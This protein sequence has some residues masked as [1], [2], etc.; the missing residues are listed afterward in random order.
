MP[1]TNDAA[2]KNPLVLAFV[3]DAY[4]T[5]Y[6]R[7]FLI[8]RSN[9]KA[10]KL[11]L[12]ANKYVCATAQAAFYE[13]IAPFLNETEIAIAGRARNAYNHTT[14]KNCTLAEYKLSTAFE[15]VV[16][17]NYLIGKFKH[18]DNLFDLILKEKL[19]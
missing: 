6:V 4:W 10:G 12:S 8:E 15:A 3:G 7:N 1:N 14:P 17:Y 19:C 11:H 13:K 16:G 2:A 5:L 9:A 18:L